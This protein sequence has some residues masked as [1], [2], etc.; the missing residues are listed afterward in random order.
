VRDL[1]GGANRIQT[2]T[3]VA[4][5]GTSQVA[6]VRDEVVEKQQLVEDLLEKTPELLVVSLAGS[7]HQ[8]DGQ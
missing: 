5:P 1:W 3:A 7:I 8:L 2:A 6:I 4:L